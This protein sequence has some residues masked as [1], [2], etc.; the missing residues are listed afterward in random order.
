MLFGRSRSRYGGRDSGEIG[1]TA[2]LV[3]SLPRGKR[4]GSKSIRELS[5]AIRW[6]GEAIRRRGCQPD[7]VVKIE[8]GLG[9]A[10]DISTD[11][12]SKTSGIKGSTFSSRARGT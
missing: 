9:A 6:E 12:W 2:R 11:A 10:T 1:A 4:E 8:R 5:L 3:I 7:R